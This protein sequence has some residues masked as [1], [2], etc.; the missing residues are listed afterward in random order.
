MIGLGDRANLGRI[1]TSSSV[2]LSVPLSLERGHTTKPTMIK[3]WIRRSIS[4]GWAEKPFCYLPFPFLLHPLPC[5]RRVKLTKTQLFK[6][7]KPFHDD[8]QKLLEAVDHLV[9]EGS[10]DF[11]APAATIFPNYFSPTQ[12]HI[13]FLDKDEVRKAGGVN[14]FWGLLLQEINTVVSKNGS[15][16]ILKDLDPDAVERWV[17]MKKAS[18]A[19]KIISME[20]KSNRTGEM[21]TCVHA[22]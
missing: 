3:F 12:V 9:G 16:M 5:S 13:G 8:D 19:A 1:S 14:L 18:V 15:R 17:E 11:D 20:M 7:L 22:T 4:N 6:V 2:S 10:A 21:N